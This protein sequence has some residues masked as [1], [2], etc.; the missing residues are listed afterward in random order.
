MKIQWIAVENPHE[1]DIFRR[2]FYADDFSPIFDAL[3]AQAKKKE[4]TGSDSATLKKAINAI[5]S[6][7]V[8]Q[9]ATVGKWLVLGWGQFPIF[10]A[11]TLATNSKVS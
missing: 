10:R 3:E 11:T 9:H 4:K 7:A 5:H 8:E 2:E 6:L 1:D